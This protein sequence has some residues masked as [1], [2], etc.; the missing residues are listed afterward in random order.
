MEA[1][2]AIQCIYTGW[3]TRPAARRQS[4][5]FCA[6]SAHAP[7]RRVA[8]FLWILRSVHTRAFIWPVF[9]STSM[10]K[11]AMS[12][13][14]HSCM[15]RSNAVFSYTFVAVDVSP[16]VRRLQDLSRG[17]S[18][19]FR[20]SPVVNIQH[21]GRSSAASMQSGVTLTFFS[22]GSLPMTFLRRESQTDVSTT[23]MLRA[24]NKIRINT[25]ERT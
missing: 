8:L 18:A 25:T 6:P 11:V 5:V 21:P 9:C 12:R 2:Q 19:N 15:H 14:L 7:C 4:G 17:D 16:V 24:R 10:T 13:V 23:S 3:L 20:N 22:P 1:A